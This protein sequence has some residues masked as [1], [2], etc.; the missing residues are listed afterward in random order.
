M[1][2][3]RYSFPMEGEACLNG[4]FGDAGPFELA[5]K[6]R[7][8]MVGKRILAIYRMRV[9]EEKIVLINGEKNKYS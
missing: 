7:G 3:S 6:R 1:G 9:P 8:G 4:I 2:M 5:E